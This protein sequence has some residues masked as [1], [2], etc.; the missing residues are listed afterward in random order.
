MNF[1]NL[2][3][4]VTAD[5]SAGRNSLPLGTYVV[6]I[7]G[8]RDQQGK[9][10]GVMNTFLDIRALEGPS[11]DGTDAIVLCLQHP[12]AQKAQIGFER[13]RRLMWACGL[14]NGQSIMDTEQLVGRRFQLQRKEGRNGYPNDSFARVPA[15][16]A[17]SAPS[18]LS[19]NF[20]RAPQ[21]QQPQV[22]QFPQGQGM[23][24][25]APSFMGQGQPQP[26]QVPQAPGAAA[27][28]PPFAQG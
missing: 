11:A 2:G 19:G 7:T 25:Q 26:M 16:W 6:E 5:E 15:G 24:P 27:P 17:P 23:A 13:L 12:D 21:A 10:P 1:A 4:P 20:T 8:S 3:R 22:P 18:G 14:E 9:E 28:M